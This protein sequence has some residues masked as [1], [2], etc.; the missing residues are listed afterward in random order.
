MDLIVTSKKD[1]KKD[2]KGKPGPDESGAAEFTHSKSATV[3]EESTGP[4]GPRVLEAMVIDISVGHPEVFLQ[5]SDAVDEGLHPLDR[6]TLVH[7]VSGKRVTAIVKTTGTLVPK[8]K[9]GVTHEVVERLKLQSG[10]SLE[11]RPAKRP[12]SV[13]L[14]RKKMDGASWTPEEVRT[15]IQDIAHG[16]LSDI[17]LTA[18]AVAIYVH[19]LDHR[20][21]VAMIDA[22]VE[23][24]ESITFDKG[25]VLDIHSIGGVPGNKYAPLVVSIVAANG[26]VIPK[27]S[28]RAISS[29]CGTADFMEVLAP[30]EHGASDIKRIAE[31]VGGTMCWGGGVRLAPADDAII[32]VEYPLSMDPH[33]QLIASVLAKKKAVGAQLVVIEIPTGAGAKVET[34]DKARRLAR[35]F[36]AVGEAVGLQVRVAITFGA[37]PIGYAIGPKLE[38][39]E[40]LATL[41]GTQ[42]P[43]SLIEKA[44]ELAGLLLELAGKA[45]KGDGYDLARKTLESGAAHKTFLKLIEMQGGDPSVK[46]ADIKAGPLE[47][48]VLSPQTGYVESIDNKALV[49]IARAAGAPRDK[50][51]GILLSHKLGNHVEKG[52]PLYRIYAE[53]RYKLEEARRVAAALRPLKIEG[54]ILE[55]V[56]E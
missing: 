4:P 32:R 42:Q 33:G 52:K 27:T 31:T 37:Q 45:P 48:V 19:D 39:K 9:V 26:L 1:D 25:P 53:H 41:E 14:I 38:A 40:A 5:E 8:G 46:S 36:I 20:E 3:A 12:V 50:G 56:M 15:V 43:G 7:Q 30:V 44:C 28:S 23:G 2:I 47:E 29:A 17:E 54:M 24:G 18:Y 11:V 21:V 55:E 22:M 51:A 6:I 35:D 34:D 10:D 13:E 49:K 16:N